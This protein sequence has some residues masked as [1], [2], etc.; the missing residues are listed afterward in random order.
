[1]KRSRRSALRAF[2]STVGRSSAVSE[3]SAATNT[4]L[5]TISSTMASTLTRV[6][7]RFMGQALWPDGMATVW[8]GGSESGGSSDDRRARKPVAST[9][10]CGTSI[11]SLPG[12]EA[13][14][15]ACGFAD[16]WYPGRRPDGQRTHRPTRSPPPRP[17]SPTQRQRMPLGE[18]GRRLHTHDRPLVQL[19][20][21]GGADVGAGAPH[22]RGDVVDQV[23]DAAAVGVQPHPRRRN[24]FFEQ[25][26]AGP[27]E[28]RVRRGTGDH[29]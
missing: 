6:T 27:I 19:R 29:R 1:M 5:P 10:A 13:E 2:A 25:R 21:G 7:V 26:F 9:G 3:N 11:P 8:E 17:S 22:A 24:A 18:A 12:Y 28:G 4:A 20:Q 16:P 15:D 23:L 14:A